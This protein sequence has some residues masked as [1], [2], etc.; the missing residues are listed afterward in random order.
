MQLN[1]SNEKYDE[2]YIGIANRIALQSHDTDHKVGC[3]I[4]KD[5]NIIAMGWNGM[6]SG[7]SNE[8]KLPSGTTKPEVLHAETNAIAKVSKST[9]SAEGATL[10]CTLSPCLECAK[11]IYQAGISRVVYT[12][13]YKDD[14]G[15]LFLLERLN[16]DNVK[17]SVHDRHTD[18]INLP[19]KESK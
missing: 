6:P 17:G 7:M 2:L 1:T 8:C 9:M 4:V 13:G 11:L 19:S 5:N 3:V 18:S 16:P 10:Y 15:I 14:S 12:K